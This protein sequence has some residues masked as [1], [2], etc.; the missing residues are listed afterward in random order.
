MEHN[1]YVNKWGEEV[2]G[3]MNIYYAALNA[4][5]TKRCNGC[6]IGHPSQKQHDC[7]SIDYNELHQATMEALSQDPRV[8]PEQLVLIQKHLD[9]REHYIEHEEEEEET[10]DEEEDEPKP[11]R[12]LLSSSDEEGEIK[13]PPNTPIKEEDQKMGH[14]MR[15]LWEIHYRETQ[16]Y[17][18][19]LESVFFNP[20]C[21][22][23][24]AETRQDFIDSFHDIRFADVQER[25]II[26]YAHPEATLTD[27]IQWPVVEQTVSLSALGPLTKRLQALAESVKDR[28]PDQF[29]K[30]MPEL[31]KSQA[32]SYYSN[33][34]PSVNREKEWLRKML[35]IHAHVLV[36][37]NRLKPVVDEMMKSFSHQ[38]PTDCFY[39][40]LSDNSFVS[41]TQERLASLG[42][43]ML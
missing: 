28:L 42:F 16:I 37:M 9:E 33:W 40:S 7:F 36:G 12:Y 32:S 24:D 25:M 26:L 19:L 5:E 21:V 13:G 14:E 8:S 17:L 38:V 29:S 34:L 10:E 30:F 35:K 41:I 15:E 6:Q 39:F 23:H 11:R 4:Q 22:I 18:R 1:F 2:A 3:L 43:K 31:L 20:I 27:A